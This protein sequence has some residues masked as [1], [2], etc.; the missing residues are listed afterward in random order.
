MPSSELGAEDEAACSTD[1]K[2]AKKGHRKSVRPRRGAKTVRRPAVS[3]TELQEQL[4]E[5]MEQ[6]AATA[7]VLRV[8][9]NSPGELAQVFAS[10]PEY[11]VRICGR[12][13]ATCSD[14]KMVHFA[15]C[16]T[17]APPPHSRNFSGA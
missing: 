4:A 1:G 12:S 8:I 11:A 3:A 9:S 5:A 6:Q 7:E 15:R 17:L 16:R 14:M 10:M 2:A 13:S